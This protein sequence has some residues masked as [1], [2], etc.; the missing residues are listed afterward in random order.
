VPVSCEDAS[1]LE[2][3]AA[4]RTGDQRCRHAHYWGDAPVFDRGRIA[5]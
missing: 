5:A 1:G 3:D 2:P 4:R